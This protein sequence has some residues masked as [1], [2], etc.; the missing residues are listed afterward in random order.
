MAVKIVATAVEIAY[1]DLRRLQDRR[2]NR[3]SVTSYSIWLSDL[4]LLQIGILEAVEKN[5][6]PP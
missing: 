2:D 4:Q 6:V 3:N 5:D 1:K